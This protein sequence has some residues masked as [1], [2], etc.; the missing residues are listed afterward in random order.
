MKH[1]TYRILNQIVKLSIENH[2]AILNSLDKFKSLES[3]P[4]LVFTCDL[5]DTVENCY[6][7]QYLT[8]N[9]RKLKNVFFSQKDN[10]QVMYTFED[11]YSRFF[12][13]IDDACTSDVLSE[14][15]MVGFYSHMSLNNSLLMHASAV[16]YNGKAVVF[17]AASGIGKTTQAELWSKYKGTKIINGDKVFLKMEEGGIYAWGSPW[18]GS[19]PYAENICAP[20]KAIVALEQDQENSIQKL[21]GF[22]VLEYLIPQVFFPSWDI[23]C[24]QEVL[25]FL[26]HVLRNTD[27]YLLKCR[28]DEDAVELLASTI[29]SI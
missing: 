26:D 27:V 16:D 11:D 10:K 2:S 28:P 7:I 5:K 23:R 9:T 12:L 14:L 17:T 24:E 20:L 29:R 8:T 19:S 4:D 1:Y 25:T 18:K 22:K 13:R 21:D 3:D 15:L 6:G